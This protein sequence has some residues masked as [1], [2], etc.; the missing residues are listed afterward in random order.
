MLHPRVGSRYAGTSRRHLSVLFFGTDNVSLATL[1]LLDESRCQRGPQAGIVKQLTVICP[2]D[3]PSGRGQRNQSVPVKNFAAQAGLPTFE[4]PF[5]V[6]DLRQWDAPLP[7]LHDIGVVVSFGY[8]LRPNVLDLLRLGAINMH[9]SLLPRH[10]GA[11]PVPHAILAGDPVTGVTI[12]KIDR[13]RF[14]AGAIVAQEASPIQPGEGAA[15]LTT[16]L[17]TRGAQMMLDVLGAPEGLESRLARCSPQDPHLATAAP[18][19]HPSQGLLRWNDATTT[20]AAVARAVAAFDNSF[21]A[22]SFIDFGTPVGELKRVRLLEVAM[23][24]ATAAADRHLP[25][26]AV[27]GTL[28]FSRSARALAVRCADGWLDIM[29]LHV[30][31]RRTAVSGVDFA[32]GFHIREAGTHTFIHPLAAHASPEMDTK[33]PHTTS[34]SERGASLRD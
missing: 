9:P 5:G 3:R 26:G 30:E 7:L 6:R 25:A 8:F 33:S 4:V 34:L 17:A 13:A 16:R 15:A 23:L 11:A 31:H 2:G 12:I 22:Y 29:R 20:A 32:N 24:G 1:R 21:G 28:C 18:R 10:R 14:D 19:L 27:P